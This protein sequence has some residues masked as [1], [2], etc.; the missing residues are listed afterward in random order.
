MKIHNQIGPYFQSAKGVRQG[1]SMSPTLFN[2]AAECL[3][4]MVRNA[5]KNGLIVGMAPDLIEK[6]VAILQYAD[7]T[8]ICL[9]HNFDSA[10]NVK[11]L[12]YMFGLM[13]RLKINYTK[14]EIYLVGGDNIIAETYV[15]MFG[16][17]VGMLPLQYLGMLVSFR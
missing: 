4:K 6:G 17:R 2:M 8:V 1:D 14:S 12:L 15:D 16:C 3:S 11:L 5:Q 7:D 10:L 9:D 13:S